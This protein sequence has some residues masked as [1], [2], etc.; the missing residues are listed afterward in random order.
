MDDTSPDL[1]RKFSAI[2]SYIHNTVTLVNVW[3]SSGIFGNCLE[4]FVWCSACM[5]AHVFTALSIFT[6][7][8]VVNMTCFM[9][10]RK[11]SAK[12]ASPSSNS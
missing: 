8:V 12:V 9:E 7:P 6:P 11:S 1:S 10:A 5:C 2:F 4:T 3:L